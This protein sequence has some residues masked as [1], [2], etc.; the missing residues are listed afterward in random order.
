MPCERGSMRRRE[1]VTLFGG[2]LA[3]PLAA[4]AQQPAMPVLG[5]M[6]GR[7]PEDSAHLLAA[8]RDGLRETGFVEGE[9]VAI[10]YRWA[11][12]DP[13][14]LPELAADLTRRPVHVIVAFASRSSVDAAKAATN[15]IPIVFGYGGATRFNGVTLK[16]S[17]GQAGT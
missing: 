12:D 6:S 5:W 2:V 7:S 13:N 3:W 1:F 9:T 4:R 14:R 10:E 16:A 17:I 8:F 11:N 15:I